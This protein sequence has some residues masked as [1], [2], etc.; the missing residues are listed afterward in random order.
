[1]RKLGRHHRGTNRDAVLYNGRGGFVAR[2]FDPENFHTWCGLLR[3]VLDLSQFHYHLP[4]SSIAQE[5][6]EDRAAS[7][8]LVLYRSE[9]RWEDRM[10]REFPQFLQPGDCLV[11]NNSK[12]FP[13]RLCGTRVGF[14]G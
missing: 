4:E 8:M 12:V 13:S 7:R 9:Q 1:M 5:P 10:F 14:T 3:W 6:L 2:S 11:L